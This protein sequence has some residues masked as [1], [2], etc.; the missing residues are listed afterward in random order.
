MIEKQYLCPHCSH[1]L[2]D[3]ARDGK[4]ICRACFNERG[5]VK[6]HIMVSLDDVL[7]ILDGETAAYNETQEGTDQYTFQWHF[8][9][10]CK[11]AVREVR[12]EIAGE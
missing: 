6:P 2:Y 9:E 10:I 11:V 3:E 5:V 8:Y 7:A 1:N 4:M 12:K